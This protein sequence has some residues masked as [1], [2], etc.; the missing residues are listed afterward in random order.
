METAQSGRTRARDGGDG[1]HGGPGSQSL[2]LLPMLLLVLLA[3]CG[4][5]GGSSRSAGPVP[6]GP[7]LTI[8]D[9]L[10]AGVP[11]GASPA[12]ARDFGPIAVGDRS[13]PLSLILEN[14]GV[15]ELDLQAVQLSGATADFRLTGT[16][17][18]RLAPGASATLTLTFAPRELGPRELTLSVTNS[19]P[20]SPFHVRCGGE[21]ALP[22]VGITGTPG[23]SPDIA[24][25]SPGPGALTDRSELRV[26]GTASDPDGIASVTVDGRS[27]IVRP[28]G[29]GS[30]RWEQT[31]PIAPGDSDLLVLITDAVGESSVA[32]VPIRRLEGLLNTPVAPAFDAAGTLFVLDAGGIGSTGLGRLTRLEEFR[33]AGANRVRTVSTA[34]GPGAGPDLL[35]P[36]D[37]VIDD[38]AGRALVVDNGLDAVLAI[39]LASGDRQVLSG[40]GI[41]LGPDLGLPCAILLDGPG[42]ALVLDGNFNN[43]A[44]LGGQGQRRIL[45][46][47]LVS[48]ERSVVSDDSTGAGSGFAAPLDMIRDGARLLVSDNAFRSIIAVDPATGDR[49]VVSDG[50]IGQGPLLVEPQGLLLDGGRVLVVDSALEALLAVDLTTGDRT[51]LSGPSRG[52]GPGLLEPRQLA[53]DPVTGEVLVADTVADHL[54]AIDPIS[55]DRRILREDRVG[56]GEAMSDPA[57]LAIDATTRIA[58]VADRGDVSGTSESA[59]V[60]VQLET[61]DRRIISG[62]GVGAGPAF[63]SLIDVALD[64]LRSRVLVL[65]FRLRALIAIEP[66]GGDRLILSDSLAGSGPALSNPI[67]LLVDAGRVL[68]ADA[69]AGRLLEIDPDTGVRTELTGPSIGTGPAL[70]SP[71]AV[72]RLGGEYVV[73]DTGLG[74]LIAID[75]TTGDRRE[76]S[77]PGRG[78]GPLPSFPAD[79]ELEPASGELF[80]V[81]TALRQVFAIDP[82]TGDRRVLDPGAPTASGPDFAAPL[83]LA[84]DASRERFIVADTTLDGLLEVA[85]DAGQRL[86][87]SR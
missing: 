56:L 52:L 12:G 62:R 22:A 67:G 33:G 65:D 64:P 37:F 70:V 15:A 30:I 7:V 84:L 55:G 59:L 76:L 48:G 10:G 61:G 74:A 85:V 3:G 25:L 38:A 87:I 49:Q 9:G 35:E 31:V 44:F 16:T 26:R 42:R 19:G 47:D 58:L 54:I 11:S 24:V 5:G 29:A 27:A 68:V 2:S 23:V 14:T 78:L 41:G 63:R 18:T 45:S 79:L 57:R 36:T 39:D 8:T 17:P 77:G 13:A 43:T 4:G 80:I 83:G 72:A 46:I 1:G 86:L 32:R 53:R 60:E 81:D 34:G 75:V 71:V 51:I 21:G 69:G 66:A 50:T 6:T 73:T 82:Q 20:D 28:T 40:P